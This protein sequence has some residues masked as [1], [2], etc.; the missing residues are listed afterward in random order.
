MWIIVKVD[1]GNADKVH[2]ETCENT[3][4]ALARIESLKQMT[5][6]SYQKTDILE[7]NDNYGCGCEE[8]DCREDYKSIYWWNVTFNDGLLVTIDAKEV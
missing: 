7:Q 8:C 2:I 1:H 6:E 4:L 3:P 5:L